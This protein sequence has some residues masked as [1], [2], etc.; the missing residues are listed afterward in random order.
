[1]AGQGKTES[2]GEKAA[3]FGKFWMTA[4]LRNN[5]Q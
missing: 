4:K 1:M 3:M 2:A 5:K